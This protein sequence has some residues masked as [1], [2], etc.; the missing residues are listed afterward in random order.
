MHKHQFFQRLGLELFYLRS[1]DFSIFR[2]VAFAYEDLFVIIYNKEVAINR[3]RLWLFSPC[4]FGRSLVAYG[5]LDNNT[6]KSLTCVL[7]VEQKLSEK[8]TRINTCRKVWWSNRLSDYGLWTSQVKMKD[9]HLLSG[10]QCAWLGD[11]WLNKGW[12]QEGLWG[13]KSKGEGQEEWRT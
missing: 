9:G 12:R 13:T 1:Y 11:S 10:T 3:T 5:V 4:I 6:I 8:L 7:I 2:I